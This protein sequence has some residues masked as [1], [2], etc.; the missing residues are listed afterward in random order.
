MD[1]EYPLSAGL[2]RESES[3]RG[4]STGA[5]MWGRDAAEVKGQ[6]SLIFNSVTAVAE[7]HRVKVTAH[8]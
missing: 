7:K 8:F 3:C 2:C 4:G 6:F 5:E 1:V